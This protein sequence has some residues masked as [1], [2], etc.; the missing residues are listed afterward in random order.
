MTADMLRQVGTVLLGSRAAGEF[1]GRTVDN[2]HTHHKAKGI[3]AVR[4]P[5]WM[6]SGC[7]A[8]GVALSMK[9]FCKCT[10]PGAGTALTTV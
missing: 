8:H 2:T 3:Q 6:N 7:F 5:R 4:H 1:G 9:D 10:K